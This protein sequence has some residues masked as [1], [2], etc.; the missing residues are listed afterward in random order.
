MKPSSDST[1]DMFDEKEGTLLNGIELHTVKAVGFSQTPIKAMCA[2][3][4]ETKI[5][6]LCGK[7]IVIYDLL[8]ESQKSFS[9]GKDEGEV[10]TFNCFKTMYGEE[11]IIYATRSCKNMYPQINILNVWKSQTK[12]YVLYDFM[13]EAVIVDLLLIG[14]GSR[15]VMLSQEEKTSRIVMF[16]LD[17]SAPF[18]NET[19]DIDVKGLFSLDSYSDDIYLFTES[20][21]FN[22]RYVKENTLENISLDLLEG[23]KIVDAKLAN[24]NEYTFVAITDQG[25]VVLKRILSGVQIREDLGTFETIENK[26]VVTKRRIPSALCVSETF[27]L[28]G[29]NL[30]E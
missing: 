27:V 5:T 14:Q 3:I 1:P 15:F 13:A 2:Y 16:N 28:I 12:S 10:S 22:L 4:N 9:R 24:M 8:T 20:E 29:Y 23:E 11:Y 26:S 17:E 30:V 25:Y 19:L 7:G 21:I 18:F 6:Y